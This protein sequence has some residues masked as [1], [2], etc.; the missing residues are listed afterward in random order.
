V[1][2]AVDGSIRGGLVGRGDVAAFILEQLAS[3][4]F[5]R[6]APVVGW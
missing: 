1:R 3:D 4:A 2:A 6:Q 5:L